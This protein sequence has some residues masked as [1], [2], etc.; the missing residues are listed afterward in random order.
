MDGEIS[1]I[2]HYETDISLYISTK[3]ILSDLGVLTQD[4]IELK[5]QDKLTII[6]PKTQELYSTYQILAQVSQQI[7]TT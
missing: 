1:W 2:L 7:R 5:K 6:S 3:N 4:D